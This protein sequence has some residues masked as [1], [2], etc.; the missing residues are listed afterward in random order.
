M[1]DLQGECSH[2][3]PEEEKEEEEEEEGQGQEEERDE[4]EEEEE[5]GEQELPQQPQQ[6]QQRKRKLHEKPEEHGQ[7]EPQQLEPGQDPMT[8]H[9]GEPAAPPLAVQAGAPAVI[10]SRDADANALR[11]WSGGA[12]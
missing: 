9:Q 10:S 1:T 3:R 5:E 6:Q 7:A 12:G 8:G 11:V 4:E 2:R